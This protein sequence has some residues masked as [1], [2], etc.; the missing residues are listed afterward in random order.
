MMVPESQIKMAK[1]MIRELEEVCHQPAEEESTNMVAEWPATPATEGLTHSQSCQLKGY[2]GANCGTQHPLHHLDDFITNLVCRGVLGVGL[3]PPLFIS[4]LISPI[5]VV[6]YRCRGD[7]QG[8][9]R[10]P[11]FTKHPLITLPIFSC[12]SESSNK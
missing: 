4:D 8:A 7:K 1:S 10:L 6:E 12:R 9:P 11:N 5:V 2:C 3:V